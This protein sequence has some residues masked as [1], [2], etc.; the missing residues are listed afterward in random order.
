MAH[1]SSIVRHFC[2]LNAKPADYNVVTKEDKLLVKNIHFQNV[3]KTED[4]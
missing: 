4:Y 3:K 1:L 2:Y